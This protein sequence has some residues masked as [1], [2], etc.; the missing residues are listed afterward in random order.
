ML[1]A[2]ALL[3]GDADEDKGKIQPK[4]NE[5]R[6]TKTQSMR[7]TTVALLRPSTVDRPDPWSGMILRIFKASSMRPRSRS[8]RSAAISEMF[9]C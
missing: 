4:K 6:K 9:C 2:A 5:R 1:G 8:A 7:P 3:F